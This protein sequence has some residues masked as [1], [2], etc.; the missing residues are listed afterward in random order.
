MARKLALPLQV[1]CFL[2]KHVVNA[3][4]EKKQ[5][6]KTWRASTF[7]RKAFSAFKVALQAYKIPLV[8]LVLD[9]KDQ[10]Y[11]CTQNSGYIHGKMLSDW[12]KAAK[13]EVGLFGDVKL[14]RV[15]TPT[16]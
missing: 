6:R 8:G 2:P 10:H 11:N 13:F 16:T 1:L 12:A 15:R 5:K 14:I 7:R 9:D 4:E 3:R